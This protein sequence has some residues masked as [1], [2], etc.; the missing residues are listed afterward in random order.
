MIIA[1]G[2]VVFA[3]HDIQKVT[4][5]N[6]RVSSQR[7]RK[8]FEITGYQILR[9]GSMSTLEED[10]VIRIGTHADGF[11]GPDPKALSRMTLIRVAAITTSSWRNRGRRMTSSYSA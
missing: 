11:R 7:R 8:V 4:R 3:S 5:R 10:V 1:V 9:P 6:I 2:R